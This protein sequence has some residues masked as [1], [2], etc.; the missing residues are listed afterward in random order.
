MHIAGLHRVPL[1][2]PVLEPP[3]PLGDV[4]AVLG[5]PCPVLRIDQPEA[6]FRFEREGLAVVGDLSHRARVGEGR[7]VP[8]RIC[9]QEVEKQGKTSIDNSAR[10]SQV[11][12]DI[13]WSGPQRVHL[14]KVRVAGSN[15]GPLHV[16]LVI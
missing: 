9:P 1:P 7:N 12:L 6:A 14:A 5:V 3:A 15:H 11:K 10:K 8:V 4:G 2:V 16:R 13:G